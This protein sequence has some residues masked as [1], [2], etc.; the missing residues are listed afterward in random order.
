MTKLDPCR[1]IE[2]IAKRPH[3]KVQWTV[4]QFLEV[5]EHIKTCHK[6]D[7]LVEAV[8][9]LDDE[10]NKPRIGRKPEAN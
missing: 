7:A 2:A 8:C 5:R 6:C 10:L 3:D 4:Q 9:R 1:A